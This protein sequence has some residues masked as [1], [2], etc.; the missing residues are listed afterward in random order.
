MIL[1]CHSRY[2]GLT[3]KYRFRLTREVSGLDKSWLT[4]NIMS[5]IHNTNYR[6]HVNITFPI[7]NR[8]VELYSSN[9][10]NNW[11][12]TTW[13]CMIFYITVLWIITWPCL[14]FSTK[15]WA[16]V[17][18]DWPFS[19]PDGNVDGVRCFTSISEELWFQIWSPAL[20][21]AVLAKR[22]GTLT[23]LDL[24]APAEEVFQ[25]GHAGVD[26]VAGVLGSGLRAFNE[27]NRALGWGEDC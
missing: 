2:D 24:N 9:R 8:V 16:V 26:R 22:Q 18:V 7:E 15:R 10:I 11:R 1:Y 12:L 14:F 20:L 4:N 3:L 17:K 23:Q 6:G 21:R 5:L 13:I 25:S 27:V 19:R